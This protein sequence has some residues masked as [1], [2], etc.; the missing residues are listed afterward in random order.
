M[1]RSFLWL[2]LVVMV[3]AP[4][5]FGE[6]KADEPKPELAVSIAIP[7]H[8][9]QR[10]LNTTDHFHVLVTN[11]SNKTVRVWTDR[12]SWGYDNLSFEQIDEAGNVTKIHKAPR[13]WSKNF[14]D[15][16][17]LEPGETYVLNVDFYSERAKGVWENVP[18][19]DKPGGKAKLVKLRAVYAAQ[20]EMYSQ[21][22]GIWTGRIVSPV[23][24][25]AIW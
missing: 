24:T 15:W 20:P 5:A 8:H 19:A 3:L 18:Q 16:L 7:V 1:L 22:H 12:Y 9:T 17:Q 13:E 6:E 21:Q 25:Y 4:L 2:A 11:V 23:G 10:S 14:P